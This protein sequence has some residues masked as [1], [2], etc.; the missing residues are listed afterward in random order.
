MKTKKSPAKRARSLTAHTKRV[1]RRPLHK[2][3]LLHPI[4]AFLLLCTGVLAL[5]STF[6][7]QAVSYDVTAT[8]PA[9]V[10]TS[11]AVV[12]SPSDKQRVSVKPATVK[13]SC[14]PQSYVKLYR[15]S[16]FS[17]ASVCEAGQ[18]SVQTDLE[19]GPNVLSPRVF[20]VTDQEGP[21]PVDST[22]YYDVPVP[23]TPPSSP[24]T[25]LKVSN[26]DAVTYTSN[27]IQVVDSSPTVSGLAPPFSSVVV[28]F[29]SDPSVCRTKADAAGVW[30]CTLP[31]V[32]PPGIHHVVI[33]A[34]TPSG[35]K[36]SFPTFQVEVTKYAEPFLLTSD[37]KYQAKRNGQ[38]CSWELGISGGTA[39][40]AIAVDWGDGQASQYV[41]A[42]KAGFTIEHTYSVRTLTEK[43]YVVL[44][45]ATDQHG[46]TTI[47][48]LTAVIKGS[49][50]SVSASGTGFSAVLGGVQRW[51]WVVWPVYIAVLL[52][53]LSFWIGERE[54]YQRFLV[55]RRM[56]HAKA[57]GRGKGR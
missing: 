3:V 49:A 9:A 32:L 41:R 20:N 36:L 7:G 18:F 28:T 23:V 33:T 52:M 4:T 6:R 27:G 39:P 51:L 34:T 14:P 47:L 5:G 25:T 31:S 1:H 30:R 37:F 44:V 57:S 10:I 24:P 35:K 42:D 8:V 38:S 11:P 55:R 22:V 46:A 12:T 45:S 29:Y 40:Y 54:A 2:K 19:A 48:Q 13:G 50:V 16:Q 53:A 17:G 43:N 26:L 15:N 21:A 56:A